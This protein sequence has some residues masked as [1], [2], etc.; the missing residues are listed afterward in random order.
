M[1][2]AIQCELVSSS[3]LVFDRSS[4]KVSLARVPS[5]WLQIKSYRAAAQKFCGQI[6]AFPARLE[7]SVLEG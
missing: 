4:S 6:V 2:A 7:N 3:I 1:A 5:L